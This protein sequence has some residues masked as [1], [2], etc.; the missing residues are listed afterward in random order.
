MKDGDDYGVKPQI[1]VP[2]DPQQER[3]AM[4]ARIV[5]ALGHPHV[6]ILVHPGLIAP[7]DIDILDGEEARSLVAEGDPIVITAEPVELRDGR[8]FE[9]VGFAYDKHLIT[10]VLAQVKGGKFVRKAPASGFDCSGGLA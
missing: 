8:A 4:T 3:A 1:V 10:D 7:H 5:R 6:D 2:M 9:E